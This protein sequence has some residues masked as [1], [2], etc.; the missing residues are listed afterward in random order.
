MD[1]TGRATTALV[2][3]C[4]YT[5]RRNSGGSKLTCSEQTEGGFQTTNTISPLNSGQWHGLG[6]CPFAITWEHNTLILVIVSVTPHDFTAATSL[7]ATSR[8]EETREDP[9]DLSEPDQRQ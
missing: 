2:E 3:A 1:S 5:A 6:S 9:I 8:Q 4:H 7:A